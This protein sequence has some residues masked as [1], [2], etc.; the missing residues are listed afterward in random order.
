MKKRSFLLIYALFILSLLFI[1]VVN[2]ADM[3]INSSL[4]SLISKD[5]LQAKYYAESS[6]YKSIELLTKSDYFSY[7]KRV[8]NMK[9]KR[10][11]AFITIPN[12]K[13][14]PEQKFTSKIISDP[15]GY[16][17]LE[18]V[19][20]NYKSINY[21]VT[22]YFR[23]FDRIFY[24]K[25]PYLN[26]SDHKE[27][28]DEILDGGRLDESDLLTSKSSIKLLDLEKESYEFTKNSSY[29]EYC[30]WEKDEKDNQDS[31]SEKNKSEKQDKEEKTNEEDID[32]ASKE[33]K[34]TDEI[35]KNK[36]EENKKVKE[37]N[38]IDSLAS[39]IR[40]IIGP[41]SKFAGDKTISI[42]GLCYLDTNSEIDCDLEIKGLL[43]IKGLPKISDGKKISV[44]GITAST[45]TNLPVNFKSE[46]DLYSIVNGL[47]FFEGIYDT[48]VESIRLT[49]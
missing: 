4:E 24:D 22:G 45:E 6:F 10:F 49:N 21:K 28:L 12:I 42:N 2:I 29:L 17:G 13:Y 26:M 18:Q 34:K 14:F 40:F 30:K 15:E 25:K 16:M 20:R 8:S 33:D 36:Q 38:R 27:K 47:M 5:K 23:I 41:N 46:Y 37:I 39:N 31:S 35:V 44:K 48:K 3:N 7:R 1:V 32:K 43:Y 19:S 9:S 11:K